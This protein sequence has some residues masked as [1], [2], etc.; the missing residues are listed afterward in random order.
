MAEETKML[1]LN[2][3]SIFE[4]KTFL[5]LL[6]QVYIG[7]VLKVDEDDTLIS[8]IHHGNSKRLDS[9]SVLRWQ[10]QSDEVWID[11]DDVLCLIPEPV[12]LKITGS[13]EGCKLQDGVF[14]N[15][16]SLYCKWKKLKV[17]KSDGCD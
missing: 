10:R 12:S 6:I 17:Q 11:R 16:L 8:F 14:T 4:K 7:K 5:P 9:N 2:C 15:V 1:M 13:R 3:Q